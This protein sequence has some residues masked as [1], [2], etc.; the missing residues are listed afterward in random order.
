MGLSAEC[1]AE[2]N[3][4]NTPVTSIFNWLHQQVNQIRLFW[5]ETDHVTR[6][7]KIDWI[8]TAVPS[9][10]WSVV[11]TNRYEKDNEFKRINICSCRIVV[12]GESQSPIFYHASVLWKQR[13][14]TGKDES[15]LTF[16]LTS[17]SLT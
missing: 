14:T 2:D 5:G 1:I 8:S 15:G 9:N 13:E 16:F 10:N 7:K 6:V 3:K 11:A 4:H 12:C 17:A